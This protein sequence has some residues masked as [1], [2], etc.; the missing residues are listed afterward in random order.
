MKHKHR[1][2][3]EIVRHAACT[4]GGTD[5]TGPVEP[6]EVKPHTL[7]LR[8]NGSPVDNQAH[9]IGKGVSEGRAE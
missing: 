6:H 1:D 7:G 3:E 2:R 5:L 8:I 4:D 9:V